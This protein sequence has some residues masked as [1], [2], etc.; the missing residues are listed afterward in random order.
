MLRSNVRVVC[1]HKAFMPL[2][3]GLAFDSIAPWLSPT[4]FHSSFFIIIFRLF[5]VCTLHTVRVS[6]C[7]CCCR[8]SLLLD[9]AWFSLARLISM[10]FSLFNIHWIFSFSV[11]V[12]WYGERERDGRC[13]CMWSQ[14]HFYCLALANIIAVDAMRITRVHARAHPCKRIRMKERCEGTQIDREKEIEFDFIYFVSPAL[15]H[16]IECADISLN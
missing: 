15:Q 10:L 16:V 5:I 12:V 6:V 4:T 9:S 8:F 14:C 2:C 13:E 7:V 3:F 1:V 11:L